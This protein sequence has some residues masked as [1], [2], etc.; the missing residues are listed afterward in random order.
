MQGSLEGGTGALT[1]GL[2]RIFDVKSLTGKSGMDGTGSWG[3]RND[4]SAAHL[5]FIGVENFGVPKRG[6]DTAGRFLIARS[7]PAEKFSVDLTELVDK[8]VAWR[9]RWDLD[10]T[11]Q[12]GGIDVVVDIVALV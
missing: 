2:T 4:E 5:L 7:V 6:I 11:D 12:S 1:V 10:V 8:I 9:A 3:A